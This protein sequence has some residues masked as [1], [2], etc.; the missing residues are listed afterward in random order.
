MIS[1]GLGKIFP[2][3]YPVG[4]VKEVRRDESRP[5]SIVT[6]TPMAK[7]DRLKYLLLLWADEGKPIDSDVD[8]ESKSNMVSNEETEDDS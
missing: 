7:L 3:G 4:T 1:S 6:V 8:N 2:E 5:F